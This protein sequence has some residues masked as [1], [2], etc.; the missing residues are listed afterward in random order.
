M[1]QLDLNQNPASGKAELCRE[2]ERLQAEVNDL[3]LKISAYNGNDLNYIWSNLANAR[4][5]LTTALE[6]SR[7]LKNGSF[8]INYEI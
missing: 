7:Q 4:A 5:Y 8:P 2:I 3:A 1:K 6:A